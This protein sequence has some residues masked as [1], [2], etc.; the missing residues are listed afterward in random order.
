MVDITFLHYFPSIHNTPKTPSIARYV[1]HT[2]SFLLVHLL[3]TLYS[4][5]QTPEYEQTEM[6][7]ITIS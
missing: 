3:V 7:S 4:G 2:P 6:L 1:D 5:Q